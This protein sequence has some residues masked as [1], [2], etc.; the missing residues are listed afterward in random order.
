MQQKR[1][2]CEFV[3]TF[4]WCRGSFPDPRQVQLYLTFTLRNLKY[5]SGQQSVLSLI[6]DN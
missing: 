3:D 5:V 4:N 6:S 2:G 1:P